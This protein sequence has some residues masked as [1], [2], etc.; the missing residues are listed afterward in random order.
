MSEAHSSFFVASDPLLG[1]TISVLLLPGPGGAGH[2]VVE[3]EGEG[4]EVLE[5]EPSAGT[6][7]SVVVEIPTTPS[8]RALLLFRIES[9]EFA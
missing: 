4:E 9:S 6:T 1:S 5:I 2:E 3:S 8:T 7:A